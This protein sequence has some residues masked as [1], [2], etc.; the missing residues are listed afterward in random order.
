MM[1]NPQKKLIRRVTL[2]FGILGLLVPV[3]VSPSQGIEGNEACA[4]GT[5]CRELMSVCSKD[6]SSTTHYYQDLDGACSTTA[7]Q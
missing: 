2:G 4:S 5:C 7:V 6:G 1:A 3:T